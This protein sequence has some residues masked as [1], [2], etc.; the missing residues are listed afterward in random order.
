MRHRKSSKLTA[1][2]VALLLALTAAACGDDG[3]GTDDGTDTDTDTDSA[4]GSGDAVEGEPAS[5]DG[6]SFDLWHIQ[7]DHPQLLE[8]P[9]ERFQADTGASVNVT[10]IENDT[11]K[12]QIRVALGANEAPCVFL[13]WGGGGLREWVEADQ[14]ADLTDWVEA[15]GYRDR[16]VDAAW[17][18]VTV[19]DRI[20]GI[21]VENSAAAF[22]WYDTVIFDDLGLEVPGTWDELIEVIDALKAE[23]IAPF[24]L[25]NS[26]PWT[27][28][29][30]FMYLVERLGGPE[31]FESAA[32]RT[33]GSFEDPVFIEA[34]ERL[35]EL[36]EMDAFAEGFNGLDWGAGQS[37]AL[38]YSGDAA[39][40]IMGSWNLSVVQSENPEY[41]EERLGV[42][43]FPAIEEGD[44][45]PTSIVGTIGDNFYVVGNDCE[46]P[47]AAFDAITYLID[48]ESAENREAEGRIPPL[49]GFETDDGVL[50]EV[51]DLISGASNVQ[52]W[53]DQYLPPELAQVHLDTTQALYALSM[54]PEE[55]AQRMEE[56]AAEY[57]GE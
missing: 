1:G 52:L 21:P 29:M 5:Y 35:Q 49:K 51:Y 14:V 12:T 23:G 57:H 9:M 10:A 31:V 24:A 34:G 26:A 27:G 54:T 8:D 28:S 36:I 40:E 55:A 38:M 56:A 25:A 30:Y 41:A 13:T 19:D 16:F 47:E 39:M 32:N 44:G 50:G 53:Y 37:R 48:D 3:G 46:H 22:V 18:N 20:Y 7:T 15:D 6:V 2:L 11:Y 33:G 4:D 43:P 42:F 45:D 17:D